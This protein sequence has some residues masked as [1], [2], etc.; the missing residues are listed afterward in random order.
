MFLRLTKEDRERTNSV[1]QAQ[2]HR[3]EAVAVIG[4]VADRLVWATVIGFST[5]CASVLLDMRRGEQELARQTLENL[6]STIDADISRNVELYDQSLRAVAS[7]MAAPEINDFGKPIQHLI[8][9]HHAAMAK[10]FGAIQVF[11]A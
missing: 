1:G 7:S 6:A 11:D 2:D 9:F 3:Q 10:H 4:E 8:L 5:I